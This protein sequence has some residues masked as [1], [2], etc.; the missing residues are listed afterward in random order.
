MKILFDIT[1]PAHVHL[2]KYTIWELEKRGNDIL[3]VA[4]DKDVTLR[5]LK[6]YGFH[7]QCLSRA[8]KGLGMLIELVEHEWKLCHIA[9]RFKPDI[10][11]NAAGTFI[12]HVGCILRIP[13][14]AFTD[15]EHAHLTNKTTFPF[16]NAICTPSC[17]LDNLGRKQIRYDGYHELAYLHPERFVP[18]PAVLDEIQLSE[19]KRFF[20][21]RFVSWNAAHDVGQRGFTDNGRHRLIE[22]LKQ[23][24]KVIITSEDKL[25]PEFEPYRI[26]VK[27][28]KIHDLLYY[29]AM[30]V[31]EG[32]TMASE[33]ALLG[34]PSVLVNSITAGTFQELESKYELMYR[35]EDENQALNRI[36]NL[37][38][39]KDLK[40]KWQEKRKVVLKDKI[41]VTDWIIR[42]VQEWHGEKCAE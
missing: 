21:V 8:K 14:I 1:H 24:G 17:Y 4:R 40:Q 30:Y 10:M 25:P 9:K 2:F 29:A 12:A 36:L 20:I 15:T 38:S 5:L 31:G 33:A 37:L 13:T 6:E 34:T 23:H 41:D 35:F 27:S 22:L 11:I 18:D 26:S 3:T 19:G 7:F 28:T 16:V 39:E 42:Y 32:G